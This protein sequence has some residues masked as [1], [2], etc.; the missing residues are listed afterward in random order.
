MLTITSGM[1]QAIL[2]VSRAVESGPAPVSPRT[3]LCPTSDLV[4]GGKA[5]GLERKV[6]SWAAFCLSV[7]RL[8]LHPM[9]PYLS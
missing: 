4:V 8:T 2:Q 7:I 9:Q 6:S 3:V 5:L 1:Q